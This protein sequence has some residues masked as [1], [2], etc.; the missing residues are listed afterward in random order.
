MA[1]EHSPKTL[2]VAASA[3]VERAIPHKTTATAMPS[4]SPALATPSGAA[5]TARWGD[6]FD[7]TASVRAAEK[8]R[9]AV[10]GVRCLVVG[11]GAAGAAITAALARFSL[12]VNATPLGMEATDLLPIDAGQITP[13]TVVVR[14][15]I[16]PEVTPM[17]EA[18]RSRGCRT[19]VGREMLQERMPLHLDFVALSPATGDAQPQPLVPH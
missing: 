6:P 12:V 11:A 9:F 19:V 7:G 15:V 10:A 4:G 8:H 3:G 14:I 18:A 13:Q 16:K 1:V 17:F 5:Q 2:N